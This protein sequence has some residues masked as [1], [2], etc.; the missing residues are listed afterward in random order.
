[1][2]NSDLLVLTG[3]DDAMAEVGDMT[4]LSKES[5][6]RRHG[7]SFL[8]NRRYTSCAHPSWQKLHF[9]KLLLPQYA[10]VLWLDADTLVT[11][12]EIVADQLAAGHKGLTV[13]QDWG[14]NDGLSPFSMGNFLLTND[15]RSYRLLDLVD[16]RAHWANTPLWEQSALQ[17]EW[18]QNPELQSWVQILPPRA[19]NSV[20]FPT[21]HDPWQPGDF[22]A[23]FTGV[24]NHVRIEEIRKLQAALYL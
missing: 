20:P 11:N 22:L 7:Y 16:K 8:S 9:V 15:A 14:L 23:H 10:A 3:Y 13:S 17:E 12:P 2:C 1:M 19:L 18:R 5:Y 21:A 6:A 4:A 24:E